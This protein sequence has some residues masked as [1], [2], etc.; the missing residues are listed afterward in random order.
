MSGRKQKLQKCAK[1]SATPNR[2]CVPGQE[3]TLGGY[4]FRWLRVLD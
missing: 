3:I 2:P 1:S 4:G